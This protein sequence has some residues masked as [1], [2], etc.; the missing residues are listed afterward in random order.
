MKKEIKIVP[1]DILFDLSEL[2]GDMP[3]EN[4]CEIGQNYYV[5]H[6]YDIE[7]TM[8]LDIDES[9]I[10]LS[11]PEYVVS[12]LY[13]QIDIY[14]PQ[15]P[16]RKF[17]NDPRDEVSPIHKDRY[18]ITPEQYDIDSS[19]LSSSILDSEHRLTVTVTPKEVC[20]S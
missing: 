8:L 15:E 7:L 5:V 19:C 1:K 4:C 11:D 2:I 14:E 6:D 17:S 9:G 20:I 10:T 13:I 16:L 3:T 12:K 18:I